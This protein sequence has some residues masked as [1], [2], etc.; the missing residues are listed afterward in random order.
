MLKL[1]AENLKTKQLIDIVAPY[2][3]TGWPH[4]ENDYFTNEHL[5]TH[6]G[7]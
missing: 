3:N 1:T 5:T 2:I 6:W 7:E 4:P